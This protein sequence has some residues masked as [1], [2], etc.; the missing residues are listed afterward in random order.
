MRTR[1][2]RTLTAVGLILRALAL[3]ETGPDT[4][5]TWATVHE[6][7]RDAMTDLETHT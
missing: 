4:W 3:A 2:D 5:H 1:T 7:M 6:H